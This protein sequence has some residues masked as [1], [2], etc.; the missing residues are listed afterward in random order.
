MFLSRGKSSRIPGFIVLIAVFFGNAAW[1][2]APLKIP[3]SDPEGRAWQIIDEAMASK[4]ADKRYQIVIA[5]SLGG[6]H[7]KVF[8]FLTKALEDKKVEVRT[9]ACASLA[10]LKNGGAVAPLKKALA[11]P[12]PE[13]FFCAAQAL[14]V[15]GDPTGEKVLLEILNGDKGS[16]SGYLSAHQRQVMATFNSKRRFFGTLFHLGI[17][18]APVP[19][20]A[21]GFSTLEAITADHKA[22]GQSMAALALA[23][24]QDPESLQALRDALKDKSP[25]VRAAA[26]HSLA[27]RNEP[28]VKEDLI[29]LMEDKTIRVQDMAAVAYLRLAYVAAQAKSAVPPQAAS[30]LSNLGAE[31]PSAPRRP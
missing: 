5:A 12:V 6:P 10:S 28:S 27:L 15:L 30:D 21:M 3:D 22:S 23:H 2:K 19:G 8:N 1:A 14:F 17:R 11:D 31:G 24:G 26:I 4:D 9:A 25:V 7:E 18:F 20:L 16:A 13:V 29:P